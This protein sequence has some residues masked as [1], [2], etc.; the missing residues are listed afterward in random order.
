MRGR[1]IAHLVGFL[2]RCNL[3]GVVPP[4]GREGALPL[5]LGLPLRLPQA[6]GVVGLHGGHP[7]PV[8]LLQGRHRRCLGLRSA[9][10]LRAQELVPLA[11]QGTLQPRPEVPLAL[12][13][14]GL[15]AG[16]P[17]LGLPLVQQELALLLRVR[18]HVCVSMCASMCMNM[19]EHVCGCVRERETCSC[20]S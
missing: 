12:R 5:R 14:L 2:H 16:R 10:A 17:L 1:G 4:Q 15:E 9:L 8:V 11:G 18:E 6:L 13:A 3:R 20:C 19:C 7:G